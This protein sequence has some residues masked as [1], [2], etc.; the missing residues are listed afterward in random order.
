MVDWGARQRKGSK[1][2]RQRHAL[3]QNGPV[4]DKES[5]MYAKGHM[6][7][8]WK[9]AS[10]ET[11]FRFLPLHGLSH[12]TLCGELYRV[13]IRLLGEENMLVRSNM[14]RFHQDIGHNNALPFCKHYGTLCSRAQCK[15]LVVRW[16]EVSIFKLVLIM[17]TYFWTWYITRT[18]H[19]YFSLL[20]LPQPHHGLSLPH[21]WKR[22][23]WHDIPDLYEYRRVFML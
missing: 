11:W 6:S 22:L 1:A 10:L 3:S 8:H 4:R 21:S 17:V 20:F 23:N 14:L 13:T 9:R 15:N 12:V 2:A 19:P 7:L 16:H 5:S 18:F